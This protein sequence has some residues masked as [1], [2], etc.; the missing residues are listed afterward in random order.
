MRYF[1]ILSALIIGLNLGMAQAKVNNDKLIAKEMKDADLY[2]EAEDYLNAINGYRKVLAL[3]PNHERA[4]LNSAISRVMLNQA[5]DSTLQHLIKLRTSKLPEVQF[6]FGKIYHLTQNFDEAINCFNKYKA[7]PEKQRKIANAEVD[8]YIGCSNNAK[9]FISQPHRSLIRNVGNVINTAAPEYVPLITPDESVMYF[10]SRREGSTGGLKD[11]SG[12]Y[13]EDVYV[14]TKE[15]GKWTS[16]KNVGPPINTNTHDA[17]VALSFDGQNMIIFREADDHITGDLYICHSGANGWS[18][19]VKLGPEINTPFIETS[20][21]FSNDTSVI[22]FSSNKPGGYGGRDL[23][24]IKK[25]P[26]GKW[27]LPYNLGPTINTS[28]DDDSPFLHPDGVTLYFSSKGHNSMGEFDVFKAVLDPEKNTFSTPENLGYPINTVNND[29]FFVL[30]AAGTHGYYSS[31]KEDTYGSSDI[32]MIDTRFGDNDLKV[33]HGKVYKG[34]DVSKAK[35]TLID[36][37]SKQVS[38]IFNASP[39]TG[40]FLLVMN[41]MK[42]YK[43]IVEE[44]GCQTMIVDLDPLVNERED[45]ELILNLTLK[46]K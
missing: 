4:N 41:P 44:E 21:C 37:E 5:P 3:N 35:I 14:S 6:Y 27:S 46:Q 25:L 38:G 13:Y 45:N 39:N 29:I 36:I 22:Y 17:C 32:Y 15:N 26:N 8:Y 10:T 11:Y 23:Y 43:A 40:K 33:K 1:Y 19:P 16:P 34:K 30:N 31:V 9:I 28:R 42:A 24:R 7:I 2:F 12:N 20:A 18:N